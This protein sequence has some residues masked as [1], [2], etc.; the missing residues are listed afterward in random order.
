MMWQ[1]RAWQMASLVAPEFRSLWFEALVSVPRHQMVPRWLDHGGSD[2]GSGARG[3]VVQDGPHDPGAWLDAAYDPFRSLPTRSGTAH[4]DHAAPGRV[5]P[6]PVTSC[7]LAPALAVALFRHAVIY[8]GCSILQAGTGSG[9]GAA[10]LTH[11]FGGDQVTSTSTSQYLTQAATGRLGSLGLRPLLITRPA[12]ADLP[13]ADLPGRY[14]RI[15]GTT[16][17]PAVPASWLTALRPGGRLVFWL[18]GGVIITANTN[19]EGGAD[20]Q[21]EDDRSAIIMSVPACGEPPLMP[22]A[23]QVT[24]TRSAYPVLDP[25][26]GDLA[27]MLAVTAPGLTSTT[28]TDPQTGVITTWLAHADGS[29]ARAESTPGLPARVHQT[30][31]RN[32]WDIVDQHRQQWLTHG[33]LPMTGARVRI[34]PDGTCHLHN[35][36]WRATIP[37]RPR[38]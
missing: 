2:N 35:R 24:A 9:Y 19:P 38:R 31:P 37:A 28:R 10:L 20:G 34:D 30:G 12:G 7:A 18:D 29:W 32:L 27:A 36:E 14:D 13:G 4:A 25:L 26:A 3:W 21:V 5:L 11:A 6:G 23:D 1:D 16:P 33:R 17:M 15:I 22:D 8:P